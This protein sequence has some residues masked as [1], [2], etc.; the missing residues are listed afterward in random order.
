MLPILIRVRKVI[1]FKKNSKFLN[2]VFIKIYLCSDFLFDQAGN[3]L[4][5]CS[6]RE[7][8]N[9]LMLKITYAGYTIDFT[10]L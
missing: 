2:K 1:Q 10:L 3:G 7:Q 4:L 6:L 5:Q 9:K 8:L